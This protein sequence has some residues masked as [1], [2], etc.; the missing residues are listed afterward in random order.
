MP[1]S[2]A[3]ARNSQWDLLTADDFLEWLEPGIFA[4]LI[5]GEKF[6]HSPVNLKHAKLVKF[7]R[8]LMELYVEHHRAGIVLSEVWAVRLSSRHVF[9]PDICWFDAEQTARLSPTQAG[10]A[11]KL[12]VEVLSPNTGDR[13]VG[14]KFSAYEEH[15]VQEYWVLD[16]HELEHRFYAR[17]GEFLV[18]F[19]RG[20]SRIESRS[21]PGFRVERAWLDPEK[22][23]PV[24]DC[25]RQL[26]G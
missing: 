5:D 16:P 8:A 13:A 17:E 2:V 4:D 26:C 23:P 20:E 18:E 14:P 21:L 11:P 6:M 9:L 19:G 22:A 15:G 12:A 7:T 3:I 24:L 1:T 10:F 25:H